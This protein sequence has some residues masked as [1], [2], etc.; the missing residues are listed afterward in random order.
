[1]NA[2]LIGDT[3]VTFTPGMPES[4][5]QGIQ[6]CLLYAAV[7]ANRGAEAGDWAWLSHYQY[8]L[9]SL[10]LTLR[11]YIVERPLLISN[12]HQVRDYQVQIAGMESTQP[13]AQHLGAMFAALDLERD[14][15]SYLMNPP[16][17]A[18][19]TRYQCV[20]CEMTRNGEFQI[21]VC[22]LQLTC[23]SSRAN[24]RLSLV[25]L[26][27]KGGSFLFEPKVYENRR[28]EVQQVVGDWAATM[29]KEVEL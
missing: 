4:H 6:D 26:N 7:F 17:E 29:I 24:S 15:L 18:R 23:T 14:A 27:A 5:K 1:M 20:P 13:L 22:G 25:Q 3:L 21:F 12:A 2:T 8:A 11:S 9:L 16:G 28:T 10:G 19:L